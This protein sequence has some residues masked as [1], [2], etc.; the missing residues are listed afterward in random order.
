MKVRKL[1]IAVLSLIVILLHLSYCLTLNGSNYGEFSI[2]NQ[3]IKNTS[4]F[5]SHRSPKCKFE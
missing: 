3:T 5:V 1:I 4:T 2:S